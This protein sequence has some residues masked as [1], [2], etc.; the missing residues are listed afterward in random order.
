MRRIALLSSCALTLT[1]VACQQTPAQG[2][3]MASSSSSSVDAMMAASSS[4]DAMMADASFS[5]DITGIDN[6]NSSVT[7]VG[8]SSII[9]HNGE[10]TSFEGSVELDSTDPSD[11][12]K[13]SVALAIDISSTKTDSQGLDG[14][15]QREDFF[16]AK[17][18]PDATFSSTSITHLGGDEY[19]ITGDLTLKGVTKSVTFDANVNN[20]RIY[21]NYNVPR[22]DFGV[23][24]DS[25]GNKLLDT[26]VPVKI[27]LKFAR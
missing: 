11:F 10:F 15:L 26:T 12:T 23:G 16:D 9:D 6:E 25:Y 14:H 18:Y 2:D 13:A 24:N 3:A 7:F 19:K 22:K 17:Q 1:L 4:A 27:E 21:A 5:G 8:G 20:D